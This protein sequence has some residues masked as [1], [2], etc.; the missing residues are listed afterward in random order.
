MIASRYARFLGLRI[1]AMWIAGCLLAR[2]PTSAQSIAPP[3]ASLDAKALGEASGATATATPDGVVKI[4]WP[5]TAV[6]VTGGG[7][8]RTPAGKRAARRRPL[9]PTAR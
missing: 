7:V 4:G 6:S 5:R 2:A 1:T 8:A 3:P 9:R